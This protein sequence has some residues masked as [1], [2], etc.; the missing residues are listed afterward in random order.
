MPSVRMSSM[1]PL[2]IGNKP[3][4]PVLLRS[5]PLTTLESVQ[6]PTPPPVKWIPSPPCPTVLPLSSMAPTPSARSKEGPFSSE[7][8]E[9]FITL[10]KRVQSGDFTLHDYQLTQELIQVVLLPSNW[11]EKKAHP[12]DE[13]VE[14][15]YTSLLKKVAKPKE[16]LELKKAGIK[17]SKEKE[18]LIKAQAEV[19]K[20]K[21][22]AKAKFNAI[23]EFKVFADFEAKVTNGS[24][25]AYEYR[26]EAC[27][28]W[29]T[30]LFLGVDV[31]CL[32]LEANNDEAKEGD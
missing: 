16:A 27:K 25:V 31:S 32:N 26:F 7:N 15:S 5:A 9:G 20:L 30:Q 10:A 17:A 28:A 23:E 24:S 11:K 4:S 12:L 6:A 8:E 13:V 18:K 21:A 19:E 29:V 2:E 3:I 1:D 22:V 14:A